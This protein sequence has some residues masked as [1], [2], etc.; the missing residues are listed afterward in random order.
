MVDLGRIVGSDRRL[1]TG[2]LVNRATISNL[3]AQAGALAAVSV[4]SLLVARVGGPTVLG[5]YSLLPRAAVAVR[6]RV[7]LRTA[8]R[9]GVLLGGRPR[10]G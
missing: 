4:A 6:S 10:P 1:N 7:L 5:E 2:G 3:G 8:D 9:I